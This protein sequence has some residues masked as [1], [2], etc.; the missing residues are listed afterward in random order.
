MLGFKRSKHLL[1]LL[2]FPQKLELWVGLCFSCAVCRF[3]ESISMVYRCRALWLDVVWSQTLKF[4]NTKSFTAETSKMIWSFFSACCRI[5]RMLLSASPH[6]MFITGVQFS[7]TEPVVL[8]QWT[9]RWSREGFLCKLQIL[10]FFHKS[11]KEYASQVLRKPWCREK[12]ICSYE[13]STS[14]LY[15]CTQQMINNV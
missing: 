10:L 6:G 3:S 14:M 8:S 12:N 13:E 7:I 9:C 4:Y 1:A 11:P 2:S 15:K 5:Y